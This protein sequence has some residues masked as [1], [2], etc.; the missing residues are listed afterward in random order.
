M[1]AHVLAFGL[2]LIM[3]APVALVFYVLWKKGLFR[4]KF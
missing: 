3:A 4:A 1:L 2:V